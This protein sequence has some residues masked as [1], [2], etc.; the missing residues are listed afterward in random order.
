MTIVRPPLAM[1]GAG[2][3]LLAACGPG[4]SAQPATPAPAPQQPAAAET[5]TPVA[6]PV[7]AE[8]VASP[9][10]TAETA[11][12]VASPAATAEAI[13]TPFRE[14]AGISGWLNSE[15]LTIASLLAGGRVVLVDFWT[16]TCI[17]CIRTFPSLKAWHERYS[18][19][20]LTI[21]GVHT[22]EFDFEHD[23]D[24]VAAA[25]EQYG[26]RYPVA[27]DN[28]YSTWDAFQNRFWPAK[29]LIGSNGA[30]VYSHF[31]EGNYAETE[32]FI[33]A[34]LEAAGYDLSDVPTGDGAG[35]QV[36]SLAKGQTREL[37][38]GYR[39][40]YSQ[41]GIYAGQPEYYLGPDLDQLYEDDGT[42]A[43]GQWFLQGL[44][45]NESEAIVH[46]RMTLGLEDYLAL[47]FR[48]RSVNV[49]IDPP[50]DEPFD[51][52]VELDGRPLTAAEAGADIVFDEE[53]RSVLRV[54]QARVYAIVELPAWG[55][56]E[57]ILRSNSDNLA[58]FAF[59]FGSYTEGA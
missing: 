16:Y 39:R 9:A 45:R 27:Q 58:I 42:R 10:A 38:G 28:D 54:Q 53:G 29:Y 8:K 2:A 57:L 3:L 47:S 34:A 12:A 13:V 15:P 26:L 43:D 30:L 17:N 48:A 22:P 37:Y 14:L 19:Y 1:I 40:N 49:V 24:N 56:H 32:E 21:I 33:R 18:D 59:T 20:G 7:F 5:T 55:E 25:I 23:R 31:G 44:W 11:T 46:A 35:P 36:D 52:V 41:R 50:R 4:G 51:V 6:T